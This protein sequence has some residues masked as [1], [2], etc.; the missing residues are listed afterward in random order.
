MK[1]KNKQLFGENFKDLLF[2]ILC[3]LFLENVF[4]KQKFNYHE[5]LT[6]VLDNIWKCIIKKLEAMEI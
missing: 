4:K 1:M 3:Y 5:S 6:P 2:W